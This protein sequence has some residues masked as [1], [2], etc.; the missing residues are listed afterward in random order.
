MSIIDILI[1]DNVALLMLLT[2]VS[3]AFVAMYSV[4][5]YF[6]LKRKVSIISMLI[7]ASVVA[8]SAYFIESYS[9]AM[10]DSLFLELVII[11]PIV[12]ESLKTAGS[13][14][15]RKIENGISVGLGFA[16][17]ENALY[18]SAF[19][20]YSMILIISY[21][22]V[23]G[24]MDPALHSFTSG[25]DSKAWKGGKSA[26]WPLASI[27]IHMGYNFLAVL[28]G[29]LALSI[30][31]YGIVGAIVTISLV[32]GSYFLLR[33]K[34][35]TKIEEVQENN[36]APKLVVEVHKDPDPEIDYSSIDAFA[37]SVN[38]AVKK[39]GFEWVAKQLNLQTGQYEKTNWFRSAQLINGDRKRSYLEVGPFGVLLIGVVV[40]IMSYIV[41]FLFFS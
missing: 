16:L 37:L 1:N 26:L 35:E 15:G 24:F 17:I 3:T 41:W 27:G 28:M 29:I 32:A 4:L 30:S 11:A 40:I 2:L 39:K 20:N 38:E 19:M 10:I 23:R 18:F 5:Y 9:M 13:T 14:Y 8:I 21:I 31:Y 34:G 22:L 36:E 6:I 33:N 12:E 25:L 7:G